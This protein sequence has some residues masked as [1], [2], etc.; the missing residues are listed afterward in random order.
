MFASEERSVPQDVVW[1][2]TSGA[3]RDVAFDL[4]VE[5]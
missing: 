1:V 3:S 5:L 4:D 2:R